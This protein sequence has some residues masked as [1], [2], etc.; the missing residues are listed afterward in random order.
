MDAFAPSDTPGFPP[1]LHGVE[2]QARDD[3][4]ERAVAD[5]RGGGA[6]TGAL[7]W[8]PADDTLCAAVVLSPEVAL[9][10]AATILYAIANGLNDCI[11]ALAPP[12][13]GVQHIWP[14]G[15]AINGARCGGWRVA[16]ATQ[17]DAAVPNWLI[18]GLSLSL[19]STVDDPGQHPDVTALAEE[20]CGHLGRVQLLESWSRHMLVWINRWEDDGCRPVFDAWLGRAVGR[21]SDITLP[22]GS[23]VFLGLEEDG[24]LVL[25]T[26]EDSAVIPLLTALEQG[27]DA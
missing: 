9:N 16:A 24:G 22:Q 2:T 14:D 5:A 4:F 7:Y 27:Q 21:G 26:G 23:G 19:T 1:L 25:G 6:E 18:V 3:P 13:V 12:E 17:D 11:G 15:I 20:G 10:A 8:S